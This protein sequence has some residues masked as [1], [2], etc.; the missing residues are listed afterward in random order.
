MVDRPGLARS[1]LEVARVI[2]KRGPSTVR[3]V[4]NE[5]PSDRGLDFKTVQTYL[6][7]LEAKEYLSSEK[8][9][10]TR[11]YR[12]RV[13]PRTVIRDLVRDFVDRLF[14]GDAVPLVAALVEDH[15][16]TVDDLDKLRAMIDQVEEQE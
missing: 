12:A 11:V 14:D 4:L 7:R 10:R 9:G 8:Q 5:L 2:W 15:D 6:R 1:E 13:R 3:D 16:L